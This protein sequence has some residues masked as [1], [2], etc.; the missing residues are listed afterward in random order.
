MIEANCATPGHSHQ[1]SFKHEHLG[2]LGI[3]LLSIS[4]H[5][6]SHIDSL[7]CLSVMISL[8]TKWSSLVILATLEY[9]LPS[10]VFNH[11]D[12]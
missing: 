8:P 11:E 9:I 4:E 6:L 5:D 2:L 1:L 7:L 12:T 3:D 10:P